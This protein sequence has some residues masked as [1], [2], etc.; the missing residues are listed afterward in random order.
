MR[1]VALKSDGTMRKYEIKIE[2]DVIEDK[3]FGRKKEMRPFCSVLFYVAS[4]KFFHAP[5]VIFP[6]WRRSQKIISKPG[7]L[8]VTLHY[9]TLHYATLHHTT[10][11]Y[12][13]LRYTTLRYATLRYATLYYTTLRYT[14]LHYTTLRYATRV[15]VVMRTSS[16]RNLRYTIL[17]YTTI[18]YDTLHYTER[19]SGPRNLP[20][21]GF[22][23]KVL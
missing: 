19:R 3:H 1:D 4:T 21:G 10:L 12:T 8:F 6:P 14:T 18:H 2:K 5:E 13:T 20:R 17:H 9:T 23:R 22:S 11:R 16:T 15:F 7:C